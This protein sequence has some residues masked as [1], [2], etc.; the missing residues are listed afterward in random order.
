MILNTNRK[1]ITGVVKDP[2]L[3]QEYVGKETDTATVYVDPES[4]EISVDVLTHNLID[5]SGEDASKGYPAPLGRDALVRADVAL[6]G[7]RDEQ[8]RAEQAENQLRL[9]IDDFADTISVEDGKNLLK[10]QEETL[11]AKSAEEHL[12]KQISITNTNIDE[13]ASD[14][15]SRFIDVD[16]KIE[17]TVLNLKSELRQTKDDLFDEL[18]NTITE[19]D[20]KLQKVEIEQDAFKQHVSDTYATKKDILDLDKKIVDNKLSTNLQIESLRSELK[21][22]IEAIPEVDL[23]LY[24]KKTDIPDVSSFIAEIPEEYVTDEELTAKGY[25]TQENV[26]TLLTGIKFIDGGTATSIFK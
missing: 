24:A 4:K 7:I 15:D 9:L 20:K 21:D 8:S 11:R 19:F 10:I 3:K 14:T 16:N 23:T 5:W 1:N 2:N 22:S 26:T 17:T 12:N 25:Y 6:V 13:F 18:D